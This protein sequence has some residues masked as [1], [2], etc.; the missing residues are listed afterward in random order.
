MTS[1][2]KSGSASPLKILDQDLPAVP[3]DAPAGSAT[4]RPVPHSVEVLDG[5]VLFREWVPGPSGRWG[6]IVPFLV[7]ASV[8]A[9]SA[10]FAARGGWIALALIPL[11]LLAAAI[12]LTALNF[13][14]LSIIVDR[15]GVAWRFGVLRRR[16]AHHEIT[17]FRTRVFE[18]ARSGVGGWGIGTARDGVDVYQVW[19]ANGTALDLVVKRGDV[20]RH[21]LVSTAAP[22]RLA[23]ALVRA[24]AASRA[25]SSG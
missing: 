4:P 15:R 13:R 18:F 25:D 6:W 10:I 2:G 23:A 20:T 5:D 7:S 24:D 8:A 3:G 14:G 1:T 22:E 9:A 12:A 16:F 17:M 11:A 19:G 21:Y